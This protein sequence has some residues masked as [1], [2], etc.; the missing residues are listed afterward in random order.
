MA[1]IKQQL[2][3]KRAVTIFAYDG[4]DDGSDVDPDDEVESVFFSDGTLEFFSENWAHYNWGA[5]NAANHVV[6]I[7]GWDDNYPKENFLPD[8]PPKGNGA[9]LVKNSWGSGEEDFP[10]RGDPRPTGRW[11]GGDGICE[12]RILLAFLLRQM[13][14]LP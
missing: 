10:N 2:L 4:A 14:P 8:V 13:H 1:A 9:W 11:K 12:F 6:T 7:V 3:A 5:G